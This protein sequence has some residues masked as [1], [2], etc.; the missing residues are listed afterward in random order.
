MRNE[1][2]TVPDIEEWTFA[3]ASGKSYAFAVH[4]RRNGEFKNVEPQPAVYIL[5]YRHPRGHLAGDVVEPLF[6][7]QTDDLASRLADHP[8]W[9][10]ILDECFNCVCVLADRLTAE[11]RTHC[12]DDLRRGNP[13]PCGEGTIR[14]S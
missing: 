7:G 5:G 11:E 12:A 2:G 9:E 13:T 3:G 1:G 6:I 8:Q 14:T 10:C 4:P